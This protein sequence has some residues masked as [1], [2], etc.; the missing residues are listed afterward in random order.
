MLA[1]CTYSEGAVFVTRPVPQSG[2][3]P[4]VQ[5][6]RNSSKEGSNGGSGSR[7]AWQRGTASAAGS[8]PMIHGVP[9]AKASGTAIQPRFCS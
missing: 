3:L 1:Q 4:P 9:L 8:V 2:L 5:N 6:G 7:K